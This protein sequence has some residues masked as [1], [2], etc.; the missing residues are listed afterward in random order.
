LNDRVRPQALSDYVGRPFRFALENALRSKN[1]NA[2]TV[3]FGSAPAGM[4]AEASNTIGA[5]NPP[6]TIFMS[7]VKTMAVVLCSPVAKCTKSGEQ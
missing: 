7:L 5:R 6:I 3:M 1:P 4:D 2:K